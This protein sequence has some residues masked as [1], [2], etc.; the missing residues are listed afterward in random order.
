MGEAVGI[1]AGVGLFHLAPLENLHRHGTDLDALG[2]QLGH[3][4]IQGLLGL[5]L[6]AGHQQVVDAVFFQE[7]A[8]LVLVHAQAQALRIAL[9]NL[10]AEDLA[11]EALPLIQIADTQADITQ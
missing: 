7:D 5:Q 11:G 10:Q 3:V 9:A 4:L 1:L 8:L 6:P 2:A